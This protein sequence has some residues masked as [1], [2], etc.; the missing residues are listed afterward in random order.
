[1]SNSHS[2][3]LKGNQVGKLATKPYLAASLNILVASRQVGKAK[4]D[5]TDDE[6]VEI[7]L[8]MAENDSN[9]VNKEF[10]RTQCW[11]HEPKEIS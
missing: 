8:A 9:V 4:Q 10:D 7:L 3:S 5:F 1:M 6:I 2:L 11:R